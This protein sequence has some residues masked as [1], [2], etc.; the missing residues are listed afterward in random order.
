ML[1]ST[2]GSSQQT[3]CEFVEMLGL[4]DN[5]FFRPGAT[6]PLACALPAAHGQA[7]LLGSNPTESLSVP[8]VEV[9]AAA[10]RESEPAADEG[11]PK[12]PELVEETLARG[13]EADF[14]GPIP[15]R[16][17]NFFEDAGD[18]ELLKQFAADFTRDSAAEEG[19]SSSM[20]ASIAAAVLT[21]TGEGSAS[22][23]STETTSGS[24]FIIPP[25]RRR[26]DQVGQGQSEYEGPRHQIPGETDYDAA[27]AA[28]ELGPLSSSAAAIKTRALDCVAVS[29]IRDRPT[30]T[31]LEA[32]S[33]TDGSGEAIDGA[34]TSTD[35]EVT[36]TKV[37]A[38]TLDEE[39]SSDEEFF[40]QP[41]FE[42]VPKLPRQHCG[43]K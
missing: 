11:A 34:D 28:H 12:E 7:D 39:G 21:A 43:V 1:G 36:V 18:M 3:Y 38:F 6:G 16:V 25:P 17:D 19:E 4:N 22:L 14:F 33:E 42:F 30:P 23:E 15:P 26:H 13:D 41:R 27:E 32:A 5:E 24:D 37:E 29:A 2:P 35:T 40:D 20:L 10:P 9:E 8:G 31:T